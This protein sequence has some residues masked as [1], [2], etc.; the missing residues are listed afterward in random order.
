MSYWTRADARLA[1]TLCVYRAPLY[2]TLLIV[3]I[4]GVLYTH[5][6]PSGGKK[7]GHAGMNGVAKVQ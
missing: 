2:G 6:C 3:N 1:R 7:K 4:M 5:S